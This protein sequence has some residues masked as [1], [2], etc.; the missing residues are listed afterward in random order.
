VI[1]K[2]LKRKRTTVLCSHGPV[3]PTLVSELAAQTGTD[4]DATL[5]RSAALD[6]GDFTVI[7]ISRSRSKK[8]GIVAVETHSPA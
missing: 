8:R 3:L 1:A 5:R 7:H 2:T 4:A 6:T